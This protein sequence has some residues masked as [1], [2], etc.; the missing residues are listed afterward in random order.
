ML[1]L[2]IEQCL[3]SSYLSARRDYQSVEVQPWEDYPQWLARFEATR[4]R[5]KAA[6]RDL[7][8]H[9]AACGP[10][11]TDTHTASV[12]DGRIVVERRRAI[13]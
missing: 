13:A 8:Q 9:V 12:V 1:T 11:E 10:V 4:L 3:L 6:E 2:I 5:S 7:A